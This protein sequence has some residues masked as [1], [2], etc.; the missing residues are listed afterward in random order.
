MAT[1]PTIKTQ[2]RG[3]CGLCI[4]AFQMEPVSDDTFNCRR[5]PPTIGETYP[6]SDV[7]DE[8]NARA[9]A[10]WP[11]VHWEQTCGEFMEDPAKLE[12]FFR[13]VEEYNGE[14]IRGEPR[15]DGAVGGILGDRSP[16][17]GWTQA[18]HQRG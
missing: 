16:L 14:N 6:V 11:L 12:V 18:A 17:R 10:Q 4:H 7:D 15:D 8:M 1:P 9:N 5:Y 13:M 3:D 2:Y